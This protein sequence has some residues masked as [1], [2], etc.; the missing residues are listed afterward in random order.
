MPAAPELS[1]A[2]VVIVTVPVTVALVG[3]VIVTVGGV[4]SAGDPEEAFCTFSDTADDV[5][6]LP[7]ASNAAAVSETI[8][9]GAVA[10]FQL[11]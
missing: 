1:L 2:L 6:E 11:N 4:V 9:F 7:A 8:P 10:E 5:A 3:L